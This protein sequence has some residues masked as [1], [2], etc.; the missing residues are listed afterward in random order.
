[1]SPMSLST[2]KPQ[3]QELTLEVII[4]KAEVIRKTFVG[5]KV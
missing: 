1:M 5:F 4:E 2:T 3:N